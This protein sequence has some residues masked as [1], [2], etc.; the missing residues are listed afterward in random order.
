V[1]TQDLY[2]FQLKNTDMSESTPPSDP[3]A[4]IAEDLTAAIAQWGE[5]ATQAVTQSL[6]QTTAETG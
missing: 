2:R 6:A 4:Q 5:A 1:V 3:I